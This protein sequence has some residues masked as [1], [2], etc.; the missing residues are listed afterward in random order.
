M[1]NDYLTAKLLYRY[2]PKYGLGNAKHCSIHKD[3]SR[4]TLMRVAHVASDVPTLIRSHFST[5]S[6]VP[7]Q[8]ADGRVPSYHDL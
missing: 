4:H 3:A 2:Q 1:H 8:L 5:H 7:L 6:Q